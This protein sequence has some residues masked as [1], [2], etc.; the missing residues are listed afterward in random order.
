MHVFYLHGFASSAQSKKAAYFL[1]RFRSEGIALRCPDFNAPQFAALTLTRMLDQLDR[2]IGALDRAP[3]TLLGSSLGAV[4][5]LHMAARLPERI[6]RLV[7]LAPA[8]MF[9]NEG[10]T[11]LDA[12]QVAAWRAQG[13]RD[14]FHFGSGEIR[15]LNYAFY[16]D[17]LQYDAFTA[18]VTQPMLIVQGL[19]DE[20]VDHRMVEQYAATRSHVTLRLLDDDHQLIASLPA[21]WN[22]IA[23]FL[24]LGP[25]KE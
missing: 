8:L 4:V 25:A 13:S 21:M 7:L 22:E 3:V 2:E 23:D 6:D 1:S 18:R 20:T 12:E 5:A 24:R 17:S 15:R 16:E 10:H 11:G 14:V 9:G 19:K